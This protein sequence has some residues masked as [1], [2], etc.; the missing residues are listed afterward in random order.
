MQHPFL[1]FSGA[2][3]ERW[4]EKLGAD[5]AV[6]ARY[7]QATAHAEEDLAEPFVTWEEANGKNTQHANFGRLNQQAN[8]LCASLGLK[9]LAEGDERCADRLQALAEH[10]ITLER[11]YAE[12]YVVRK[13]NP[14]HSDLCSTAT[15]LA[16]ARIFDI[17]CPRLT[18]G[19]RSRIARGIFEKG[20]LPALGDWALPATRIHALDSMGHNWWAVCIAEAATAL[21][22]I[23]DSLPPE[24]YDGMLGYADRALAEYI[25]YP[26]NTLFNKTRNFDDR[27]MFYE[28]V[29]YDNYGTG[30]LLRYLWCS[31]RICGKNETIRA[32]L[33]AGLCEAPLNFCYPYTRDGK[34]AYM[35]LNFCDSDTDNLPDRIAKYAV[36]LGLDTAPVR[37]MAAYGGT[38]VWDD[39][40]GFDPA[41]LQGAVDA[42][43]KTAVF[44][45]G[46]A[47]T[48]DTWAPD[49][50]LLA[51][52]SG[53]CWNHS[54]NDAGSFVIFHKGSPLFSDSGTCSYE[55]P[56]YH[57]FYCQDAAHSTLH[58]G[59]RGARDEELYRGTKFPGAI[60]D[61]YEGDGF[62]FMQAD[63]TGPLAHLCSRAYRSFLWIEDRLLVIVD[64]VFCHEAETVQLSLHFDGA[65]RRK[66]GALLFENGDARARVL[67]HL[68]EMTA[69]E[70]TGHAPGDPDGEKIY[71]ELCDGEKARTHTL[72]TTLELDPDARDTR[73][74]RL[75]SETADGIRITEGD[76]EREIWYNHLA[77]GHV[78]H[79]NSQATLGGFDTDAYLL[80][81][82]RDKRERTERAFAVCA[83]FLRRGGRV[84]IDSFR[85]VTREAV[86]EA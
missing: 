74:E 46:Y 24:L 70:K 44:S 72:I 40:A 53:F 63:A 71:V 18:D 84:Y 43:P 23:R 48:R 36:R 67:T 32:A 8:K 37:A 58:I 3:V 56:L 31:E 19:A 17:I 60:C 55:S 52:R 16:L 9:Y 68:P 80:M 33:P 51:V 79:D 5:G 30:T 50:T 39:L 20:V 14:W 38:D 59:G 64:D 2:D 65:Y 49:G 22:A 13:P 27:A 82:T 57:A 10:Y 11:W 1:Y 47:L 86:T 29:G 6:R 7:E 25:T 12:S 77:D 4:R 15:T 61:S 69:A 54:H 76:T 78:M 41:A 75:H 42:L 83:S 34:T 85:K 35:S 45:S 28:G 62:V 66:N 26:G 21:L 73:F 81:I